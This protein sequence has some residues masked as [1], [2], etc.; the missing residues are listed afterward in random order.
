MSTDI[1]SGLTDDLHSDIVPDISKYPKRLRA[2][3]EYSRACRQ[4]VEESMSCEATID[5][6]VIWRGVEGGKDR[7]KGMVDRE[8]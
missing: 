5:L 2:P 4:E 3:G 8:E 7:R 1:S 6:G